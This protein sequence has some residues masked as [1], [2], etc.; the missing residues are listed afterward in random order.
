M[1]AVVMHAPG[2]VRVDQTERPTIVEPTDAI[3]KL[4]ATC[5]CGSDLWPYRG[6]DDEVADR[7][8]GDVRADLLD[9]ADV[10]VAH[11]LVVDLVRAAVGPQVGPADAGGG[12]LDD[13][14]GR[15]DDRR[16][17]GLVE[18]DVARGVHDDCAHGGASLVGD[19]TSQ[20]ARR[21]IRESLT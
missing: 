20:S 18:P 3:I 5:I 21:G 12:E 13:R 1:R 4:A 9:D 14:V 19:A 16:P 8:G 11:R 17:L 10:L 15:L 7:E 2:D 6:A